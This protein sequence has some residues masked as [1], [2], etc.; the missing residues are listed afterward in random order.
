MVIKQD[1]D[2]KVDKLEGWIIGGV[3][4]VSSGVGAF[5]WWFFKTLY[6]K[7]GAV[8]KDVSRVE[9][10]S[11]LA[12]VE[13]KKDISKVESKSELAVAKLDAR[14]SGVIEV[15]EAQSVQNSSEHGR[16]E[17][18]MKE[19]MSSLGRSIDVIRAGQEKLLDHL[20][21]EKK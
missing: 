11:D 21:D 3:S 6:K 15:I 7:L 16:I 14:V 10:K 8:E 4:L 2:C 9:S 17:D 20:L 1:K 5:F 19:G 13:L 12:I 18:S